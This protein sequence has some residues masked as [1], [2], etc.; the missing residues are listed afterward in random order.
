[1]VEDDIKVTF[2]FFDFFRNIHTVCVVDAEFADV[3]SE[4]PNL[5]GDQTMG[6]LK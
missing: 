3:L 6:F 2:Q 4:G 1:L 5:I